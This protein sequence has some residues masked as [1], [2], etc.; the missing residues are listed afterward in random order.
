MAA[1][2]SLSF[3]VGTSSAFLIF[4]RSGAKGTFEPPCDAVP[5]PRDELVPE[6]ADKPQ[7][8]GHSF[9]QSKKKK[10][11]EVVL[12][13]QA[14]MRITS[15]DYLPARVPVNLREFGEALVQ[16]RVMDCHFLDDV[17][18]FDPDPVPLRGR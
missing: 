5:G 16:G 10:G 3:Q 4:L 1:F 13:A 17:V 8:P 7:P 14:I 11:P 9:R 6:A 12:C 18:V 2:Q 15:G